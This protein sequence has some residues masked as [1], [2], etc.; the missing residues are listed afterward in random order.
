M[1]SLYNKVCD[2]ILNQISSGTLRVGDKLPPEATYAA[3]LGVSRSTLR[4]AFSEL[5]ASGVLK[6]RKRAGTEIIADTPKKRFSMVTS[7]VNELLNFG[8][9][10]EL[11][12]TGTRTVRT[13][14]VLVL[15]GLSSETGHWLEVSGVRKMKGQATPFSANQVYVP[16]RFAAIEAVIQSAQTSV[17]RIIE[18]TF[19]VSIGRVTQAVR[20]IACP[21]DDAGIIGLI[22]GAPALRIEA[23]L[24]LTDGILMEVSVATFDPYRFQ[25]Q[26]DVKIE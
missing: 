2:D 16:A 5:V 4:A 24:Y 6:R 7:G 14:E 8:D 1:T 13:E 22:E 25:V 3:E 21:S 15:K 19:S 18:D 9:D 23:Q 12:V 20:A 10:T 26:N 17:F 11:S